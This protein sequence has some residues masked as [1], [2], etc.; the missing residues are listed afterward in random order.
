M[1]MVISDVRALYI[2][3]RENILEGTKMQTLAAVH[4]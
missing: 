2:K 3:I 1:R 4:I